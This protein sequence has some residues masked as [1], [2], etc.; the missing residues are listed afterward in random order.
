MHVW[1]VQ[2]VG[3]GRPGAA[4]VHG[5]VAGRAHRGRAGGAE[6]AAADRRVRQVVEGPGLQQRAAGRAL[7]HG[8]RQDLRVGAEGR[9]HGGGPLLAAPGAR[10]G[11]VPRRLRGRLR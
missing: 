9:R 6:E 2:V 5:E 3:Q 11:L 8:V 4:G 7:R 10:H 1:R